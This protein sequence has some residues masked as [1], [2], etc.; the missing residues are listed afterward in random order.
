MSSQN[1]L[2]LKPGILKI[3][4]LHSGTAQRV[5]GSLVPSLKQ[6]APTN[7]PRDTAEKQ[8]FEKCLGHMKGR[9]VY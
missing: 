5:R 7:S 2:Y 9:V 8:Q 1:E 6:K 4:R 3:S